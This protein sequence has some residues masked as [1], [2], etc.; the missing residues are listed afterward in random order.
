MS[1]LIFASPSGEEAVA[2]ADLNFKQYKK[3][4]R[5]F[6]LREV[7]LLDNQSTVD[8]FCN[9]K[10]VHNIRLAPE[11]LTLKS[12]GGELIVRHIAEVGNYAEPVW[13]SNNAIANIFPLR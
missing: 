11:S 4:L 12:N 6:N 7:I 5:G 1:H 3:D 13:F 10:F 8:L 2:T 9:R